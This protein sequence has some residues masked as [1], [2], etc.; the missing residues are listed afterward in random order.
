MK[1]LV[2]VQ[3]TALAAVLFMVLGVGVHAGEM[4]EKEGMM[5]GSQ[6]EKMTEKAGDMMHGKKMEMMGEPRQGH[7]EEKMPITRTGMFSGSK[8]HSAAGQAV[9]SAG[10]MG[11]V[12]V[13]REIKIDQVPDGRVYLA[14]DADYRNGVELGRLQQFEG[15]ITFPIPKDVD[16]AAFNSVV[17]WC[18]KFDVEIGRALLVK[19][20]M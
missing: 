5:G 7:M 15:T 16:P 1:R 14:R 11:P 10:D 12:L 2:K 4:K 9:L 19:E 3:E 13:L 20:R 8:G 18:K 17:I 6:M